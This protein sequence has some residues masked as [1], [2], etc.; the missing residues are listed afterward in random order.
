MAGG[1]AAHLRKQELSPRAL[2]EV[3]DSHGRP[4]SRQ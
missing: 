1:V 3:W 4:R 2:R